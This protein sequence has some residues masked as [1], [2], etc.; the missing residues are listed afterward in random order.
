[1]GIVLSFS[2][3]LAERTVDEIAARAEG[4][5]AHIFAPPADMPWN[6]RECTIEDPD[7]FR[8]TFSQPINIGRKFEDVI[9]E[10]T[11]KEI[12]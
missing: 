4:H 5:G 11:R 1:V 6:A 9:A 2:A 3:Y 7:G 8:L 10:A 12:E